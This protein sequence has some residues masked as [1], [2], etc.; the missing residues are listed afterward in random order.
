MK[1]WGFCPRGRALWGR[2]PDWE[3]W[4]E[5]SKGVSVTEFSRSGVPVLS[6]KVQWHDREFPG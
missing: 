3:P 6:Q 2:A 1:I 5:T 4:L